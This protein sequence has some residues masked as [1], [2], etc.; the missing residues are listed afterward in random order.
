MRLTFKYRLYPTK[1]QKKKIK[2]TL[3]RCRLLYNRLLEERILT[4][5]REGKSL[6]YYEQANTFNERK[7]HIPSLRQVHSQVLQDVGKRLDK[8]FQSFFRRI[9]QGE[10]PGFPRYKPQQQYD[11][12][13]YPQGGYSIKGN[14]LHLSKIGKVTI[15]MHRAIEGTVKT[16]TI[17]V[18]NSCYYACFSCEVEAKLLPPTDAQVGVDLGLKY[19]AVPS[20]GKPFESPKYLRKSESRLKQLQRAVSRKKK[21]SGRRKKAVAQLAKQ[22]ARVANQRKDYTHKV[23]RALVNRYGFI[24]FEQLHVQGMIKNRRLSKSIADAGWSQL[25]TFTIYKAESAGRAVVQVDP[26]HTSQECSNCGNIVKKTLA[27]RTHRCSCGYTD[28]RDVNA[29][30]NILKRALCVS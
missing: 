2:F 14:Q 27:E 13:T 25:V 12:F 21:G 5:K 23:S 26:R 7:Q 6:S 18:K 29:A 24:A 11:S 1:E 10:K 28:D 30:R 4:F 16:C 3:E 8:A 20:V 17:I 9:K 22:H 19:L 15:K